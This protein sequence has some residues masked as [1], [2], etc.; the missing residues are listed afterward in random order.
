MAQSPDTAWEIS[1]SVAA[2]DEKAWQLPL[3]CSVW[4]I[5]PHSETEAQ[6][7]CKS[8]SEYSSVSCCDWSVL[9]VS[10]TWLIQPVG[11]WCCFVNRGAYFIENCNLSGL[12][13]F[14]QSPG[15]TESQWVEFVIWD[16]VGRTHIQPSILRLPLPYS[17]GHPIDLMIC[18]T[19][20]L[21][22]TG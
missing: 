4:Y 12:H 8:S 21:L 14:L 6:L 16:L 10:T 13:F 20:A 5:N 7:W 1:E 22:V 2:G 11:V 9:A 18:V 3:S 17:S 15:L 19:Y